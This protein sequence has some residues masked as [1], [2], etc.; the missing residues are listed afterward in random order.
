VLG[1][2]GCAVTLALSAPLGASGASDAAPAPLVVY[3]ARKIITMEA[4][5]PVATAVAVGG[6][7][8]VAVGSLESMRPWLGSR[9]HRVD[10]RFADKV[11]LP[12]LIEPHLHPYIAALLL[13]MAFV[14]PHD[15]QLPGREI[16]GVRGRA[17]YLAR[18]RELEAS[19]GPPDAWLWSWGYHHLFH[20]ELSRADLDAISSTRP[21]I[22]W[23]RS[24]HEIYANTPALAAM[25]L[26]AADVSGHPAIDYDQ[27]HFYETGLAVAFAK[28]GPRLLAP[29]RYGRG[30]ALAREVVHRGGITTVSDGA[31]G[32]LDLEAEW[33]ALV[34]AWESD[35]TPFRTLLLPDGRALGEKLGPEKA[36]VLMEQL[37]ERNTH[38]LRFPTR[39][40]KLFTDGAF[41]SQLMQLGPPGYI[42]GHHGEWIMTPE[43]FEEAAHL[44]WNAGFQIHVH[45]NGDLGVKVALDVLEKLQNQRPRADHRFALHHLG[46]STS[47][48]ARRMAALGAIVSA[49]PYY[50]WA[51]GDKYS[52]VGLGPERASQM[53]RS[54]SLVRNGVPLSFHSDFTMAPAQPLLLA[55]VAATRTT[56]SG[57]VLAPEERITLDQALRAVTLDAA[58]LLRMEDRIGSIAAGKLA[59]FT[60]L[61]EDPYAAPIEHLKDIE[62]WGTVF[63]GRPYP[64]ED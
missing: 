37:P 8:I 38:R 52:E 43:A 11:L 19:S 33:A 47:A 4:S 53:V 62:I 60:V 39:A 24:F 40:V 49:N 64:I 32:T 30:L 58:H 41:Y 1:R 28:L 54:G 35:A 12:G 18:L 13:P 50:L 10:R 36:L 25:G 7:R 9:E 59:D 16:E 61:E 5:L 55:W 46:Y 6:D 26:G 22:V 57:K 56:A 63:E 14:T 51:L 23:H 48:Q 44:Y 17:A 15:W 27:G 45:A 42:D 31:F 20:G 3:P 21:I 29:E 34:S 2:L